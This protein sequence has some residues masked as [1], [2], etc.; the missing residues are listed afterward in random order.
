[1]PSILSPVQLTAGASLLQNQGLQIS[2]N[3]TAALSA[4][5]S[6]PFVSPL[7]YTISNAGNQITANTLTSLKSIGSNNCPALG[8]S[9]PTAYAGTIIASTNPPGFTGTIQT[10][11]NTYL[12][13]GDL[14]KFAQGF[15]SASSYATSTNQF[16]NSAVNS[17][18]Y[19][20]NTFTNT[21]NMVTGSITGVN[22]ATTAFGAD[23]ANLG[24]LWN[25]N[26]LGNLGSP[27][28]LTQQI[29]SIVGVIPALSSAFV[30][31][32][33]PGE[34]IINITDPA[35]SVT[36]TAQKA[37]YTA[38]TKI[39]D[40]LLSQILQIVGVKTAGITTMADLLNPYLLFPTS[41]QSLT[42]TTA[43]GA[44][45]I[46]TNPEGSINTTLAQQLPPYT[47]SSVV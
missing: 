17:Q 23:L 28:A 1:V 36:D 12:G 27:L 20:G 41:F 5:N 8:D 31:E 15:S 6:Q 45:A 2:A 32:G 29:Y 9:V 40:P 43:Q 14:S 3:L 22:L 38:M 44:R 18:N 37:M 47:L 16:I 10:T 4:Y 19:L 35:V 13:N 21:N 30:E 24:L 33:V 42:V 7:L 11:A 39:K 26:N 46:Y 25:L 34:V